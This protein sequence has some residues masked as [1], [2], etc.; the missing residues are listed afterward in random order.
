M[1]KQ[2]D[3]AE[4]LISLIKAL[5]KNEKGIP[6]KRAFNPMTL[7]SLLPFY[8]LAKAKDRHNL[9]IQVAGEKLNDLYDTS[10]M[11]KY[12]FDILSPSEKDFVIK[13]HDLMLDHPCGVHTIRKAKKQSGIPMTISTYSFP[14]I[15]A[16]GGTIYF[17]MYYQDLN[18]PVDHQ[19]LEG[20]ISSLAP[21]SS[22]NFID[23]GSSAPSTKGFIDE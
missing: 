20:K 6:L 17:L 5:P 19:T 4:L 14:L 16:D 9:I 1:S 11:G 21:Y 22:I 12:I 13:M 18:A 7:P 15:S 3:N 23:I 8:L 2:I 10:L